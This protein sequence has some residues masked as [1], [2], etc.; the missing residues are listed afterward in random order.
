MGEYRN[1]PF[2]VPFAGCPNRCVFC[3]QEKITGH[4]VREDNSCE[5]NA[6]KSLLE[7]VPRGTGCESRI[8][9]FGGSFTAIPR[10][11]MEGLLASAREYINKG[12]A[13]GI[14]ISTRPDCI[15]EEI[16]DILADY[17]VC[18]IELGIQSTDDN[19]LAASGRG[20][21]AKCSFRAAELITGRGFTLGGQ[22]MIGLPG[23]TPES[24]L[25][26]A[27]DIIAMGA[28]ESRI[29]PTVVF[30]GT[31]LYRMAVSGCYKPLS[32]TEAVRRTA[33]CFRLFYESGVKV[34]RIGLHASEETVSA[35]F[36]ATHP[37]I[38]ELVRGQ[39][40]ADI[41]AG[42]VG[43]AGGKTLVIT[44]KKSDVSMLCG[45]G[46]RAIAAIKSATNAAAVRV[47]G[48]DRECFD[49]LINFGSVK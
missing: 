41:I 44:V 21:D 19:V 24:E 26:T 37:A 40:Y 36:G 31:E 30:S 7:S 28:A 8:A 4:G 17:G 10:A 45:H 16:L 48:G 49:P 39:V 9:F 13:S 35:P 22:M 3:A 32:D 18:N 43:D 47:I 5:L 29:Y 11:R 14:R 25:A 6:L 38:G 20:H 23:A 33:P 2:F 34:L 27:R 42:Q 1:I 12:V 46:G 15:N